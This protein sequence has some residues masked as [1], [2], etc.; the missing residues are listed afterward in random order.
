VLKFYEILISPIARF[1]AVAVVSK[2]QKRPPTKAASFAVLSGFR[3]YFSCVEMLPKLV[4][5]LVPMPL[6]A[7]IIT[8][9]MPAAIRP[10]SMAVAP[11]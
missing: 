7:A 6:T 1:L 2:K 4:F 3:R 8:T 9:E 5:S 11:D 10:Y